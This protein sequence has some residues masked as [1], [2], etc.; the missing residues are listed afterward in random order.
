[1][2]HIYIENSL[3]FMLLTGDK[4][5]FSPTKGT[6]LHFWCL[7][8]LYGAVFWS[9][10]NYKHASLHQ[11]STD[12]YSGT[13]QLSVWRNRVHVSFIRTGFI[14]PGYSRLDIISIVISCGYQCCGMGQIKSSPKIIAFEYFPLC[15]PQIWES[16]VT[17]VI[18]NSS[19][20]FE[21]QIT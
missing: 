13:H 17:T 21:D 18:N 19:Y 7:F 20:S 4:L 10:S 11:Q 16:A 3:S 14:A 5:I 6:I 15:V 12:G 1:M 9:Q 8:R 2:W